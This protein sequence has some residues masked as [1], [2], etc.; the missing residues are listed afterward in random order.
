MEVRL[1]TYRLVYRVYTTRGD[2]TTI[3]L[4]FERDLWTRLDGMRSSLLYIDSSHIFFLLL[5]FHLFPSD[6]APLLL[7]PT[8]VTIPTLQVYR[9]FGQ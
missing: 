8:L 6:L 1:V 7:F 3:D 2:S 9:V 5:L 4:S